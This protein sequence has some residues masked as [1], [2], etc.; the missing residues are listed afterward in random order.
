VVRGGQGGSPGGLL[1]SRSGCLSIAPV[2]VGFQNGCKVTAGKNG[3]EQRTQTQ[4]KAGVPDFC[5]A[6][7]SWGQVRSQCFSAKAAFKHLL[8][9]YCYFCS[10]LA[11]SSDRNPKIFK[12]AKSLAG[13]AW[14]PRS[15]PS[16]S[17]AVLYAAP[18]LLPQS[19]LVSLLHLSPETKP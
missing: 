7:H 9:R 5:P 3:P 16:L 6:F 8:Q 15:R 12:W 4:K 14:M 19:P 17:F 2:L 10:G 11:I 18:L 1:C 13:A